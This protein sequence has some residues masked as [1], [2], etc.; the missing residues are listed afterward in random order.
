MGG[1]PVYLCRCPG[2]TSGSVLGHRCSC[3]LRFDQRNDFGLGVCELSHRFK[4]VR[5]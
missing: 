3:S 1:Q 4:I 5:A 2:L